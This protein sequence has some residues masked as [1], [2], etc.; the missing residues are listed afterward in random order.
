MLLATSNFL[1]PGPTFVVELV[2]FLATLGILA[3]YVLPPLNRV[4]DARQQAIE[5]N[6]AAAEEAKAE[7]QRL[8]DEQRQALE[9]ARQQA[10]ASREEA[11]KFGE[12]LRQ[13]LQKKGEEE[14]QRLIARAGTDIEA[15]TRKAAEQLRAQVAELVMVV[16]EKVLVE[17]VTIADQHRLIDEAIV[18][19]EAYAATAL[20]GH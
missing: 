20:P 3:K 2:I 12:Q 9:E 6:I 15:A 7:A 4:M 16:V 14:Y 5:A 8:G 19:V 13:E 11:V 1:V 18:E 17:G 10:R